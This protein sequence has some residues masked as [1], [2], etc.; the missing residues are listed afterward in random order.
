MTRTYIDLVRALGTALARAHA[1]ALKSTFIAR[2]PDVPTRVVNTQIVMAAAARN[3]TP[4]TM[5]LGGKSPVIVDRGLSDQEL[6]V[7]CKR[8]LHTSSYLNAGQICVAPDY[9]M[10]HRDIEKRFIAM[11]A[12]VDKA[13]RSAAGGAPRAVVN[14]RHFDRLD[15]LMKNPGGEVVVGG[16]SPAER[17]AG[18]V[19]A[20]VVSQPRM[21][22]SLMQEEVRTHTHT[23][24]EIHT[25]THTYTRT[26]THTHTHSRTHCSPMCAAVNTLAD[27]DM[28]VSCYV[29]NTFK[30]A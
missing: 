27:C 11:L 3:L 23:H 25:H 9:V 1:I 6:K 15:E 26:H 5:E 21:D 30:R 14:A 17:A 24:R 28:A 18:V 7:A 16:M 29:R 8:I 19:P 20:T 2:L 12:D 4:V 22:S 13:F 10:V